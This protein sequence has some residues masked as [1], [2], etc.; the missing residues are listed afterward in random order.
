MLRPGQALIEYR[1]FKPFDFEKSEFGFPTLSSSSIAARDRRERYE[2]ELLT[3]IAVLD[4]LATPEA[5][6]QVESVPTFA[7]R[8]KHVRTFAALL[9]AA[10]PPPSRKPSP[11]P[12]DRPRSP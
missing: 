6:R 8:L 11:Q 9:G 5:R 1:F 3:L 10:T 12:Q 4:R 7:A 2:G